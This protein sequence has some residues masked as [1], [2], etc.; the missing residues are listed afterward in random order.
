MSLTVE[1]A[2]PFIAARIHGLD[3][4]QPLSEEQIVEIEQTSGRYPVL[5][6]PRQYINDDQLLAFAANFGPLQVAV[7]YTTR[8]DDH[9]LAPMINDI[10]NLGKD[11]QTFKAGDR[12]RMNNLTSRR[13]H[14]DASYLPLPARYSMLL[15]Y[16]VPAVGGQTQFADMRAAYDELPA[17]LRAAVEDLDCH[18]DIMQS[19]AAAGFHDFPDEE[20]EALAPCI[21]KL[22]RTHPVSGRKSLYL[23]SHA[24]HVV[25][26]PEPEGRDLLRE[27]TEF[28]T[29]PQFVYAHNWSVRDL[30]VWD[31][32][33][34]MH[35]GRPHIPETDVRE[36]HRAT[37][38]DDLTWSRQA[39]TETAS[40]V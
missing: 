15:S 22:V 3:L 1:A 4:S 37:T 23:S 6:F 36:M 21:H 29:Q 34:L 12:R 26:W 5:I 35:R 18:Y 19:R 25:G 28:A 32:R 27:L 14:S 11:N 24:S 13:W 16:V 7:S 30:V 40:A 8:P 2:H 9:R 17:H 33:A 10:S 31:N 39:K 20:R 38:L